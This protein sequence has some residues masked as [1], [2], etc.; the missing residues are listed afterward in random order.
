MT[1]AQSVASFGKSDETTTDSARCRALRQRS[2]G[3]MRVRSSSSLRGVAWQNSTAP[4]PATSTARAAAAL[5]V[6][7]GSL[8]LPFLLLTTR[9]P[10]DATGRALRPRQLGEETRL[11]GFGEALESNDF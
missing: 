7:V 10:E 2:S 6:T 8:A 5:V 3:L 9:V 1:W 11:R 4:S